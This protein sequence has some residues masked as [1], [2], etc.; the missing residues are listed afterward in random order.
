MVREHEVMNTL[1]CWFGLTML[2]CWSLHVVAQAPLPKDNQEFTD[3]DFQQFFGLLDDGKMSR[4]KMQQRCEKEI[5]GFT[6]TGKDLRHAGPMQRIDYNVT[7]VDATVEGRP[8]RSK[9]RNATFGEWTGAVFKPICPG[10]YSITVN[11]TSRLPDA[12]KP[13]D[14]S[15]HIFMNREGDTRPGLKVLSTHPGGTAAAGAGSSTV[16]L[17][18][19]TGDEISTW[20]EM[21][22]DGDR[23][24]DTVSFSAAKVNDIPELT[25]AFSMEAWNQALNEIGAGV[26]RSTGMP[27]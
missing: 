18:M 21:A 23:M 24:L 2:A 7:G 6:F 8:L 4:E 19:A 17:A 16:V 10:L 27:D 5:V 11:F 20:T 14:L 9:Y 13:A 26:V 3:Q 1:R 15:L 12:A 25:K 22:G